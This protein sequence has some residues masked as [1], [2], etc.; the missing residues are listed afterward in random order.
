VF[1]QTWQ[2]AAGNNWAPQTRVC[3]GSGYRYFDFY[4]PAEWGRV[5]RVLLAS[6]WRSPVIAWQR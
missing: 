5:N 3:H 4:L 2:D 1:L 6:E